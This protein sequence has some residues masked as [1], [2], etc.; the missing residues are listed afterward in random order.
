M[1]RWM[2]AGLVRPGAGG[3][4]VGGIAKGKRVIVFH[5][6]IIKPVTCTNFHPPIIFGVVVSPMTSGS[7]MRSRL[8]F[9]VKTNQTDAA[10][11]WCFI[12]TE[13]FHV[14]KGGVFVAIR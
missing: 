3:S 14:E 10:V 12:N 11:F 2:I 9:S 4:V 6:K 13:F 8:L 7:P 5:Y 1:A